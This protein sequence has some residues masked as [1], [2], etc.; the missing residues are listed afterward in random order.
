MTLSERRKQELAAVAAQHPSGLL[1]PLD[2]VEY[3]RDPE[4]ALHSAFQWDDGK[5]AE[6]WRL[7]Q[8]RQLIR[9]T[10]EVRQVDNEAR[11]LPMYVSIAGD[12]AK[13]NGGYRTLASVLTDADLRAQMLET[14]KM[15]FVALRNR[16]RMLQEWAAVFEAIDHV[17]AEA[18]PAAEAAA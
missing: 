10:I 15:E 6:S 8:A 12:R 1:V 2:V 7:E 5:A 11:T 16:Y 3:A 9:V 17:T 13:D 4:T 18:I 14:S